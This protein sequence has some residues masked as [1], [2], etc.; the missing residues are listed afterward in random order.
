MSLCVAYVGEVI[1][2]HELRADF[3][4][5]FRRE[6]VFIEHEPLKSFVRDMM[7]DAT[8]FGQ[9]Y[10]IPE[11]RHF[12]LLSRWKGRFETRYDKEFGGFIYGKSYYK[13][14]PEFFTELL[15]E[16]TERRWERESVT[17]DK[18]DDFG[19]NYNHSHDII[20]AEVGRIVVKPEYREDFDFFF[21]AEFGK[22][23]TELFKRFVEKHFDYPGFFYAISSWRHENEKESWR[24]KYETSY[25][26][27]T[28]RFVYGLSCKYHLE[29]S[30]FFDMLD[31]ITETEVSWDT[32][33]EPM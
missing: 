13:G 24:G 1:I 8:Q 7:L 6:F 10:D 2:K 15:P 23:K 16:I 25:D 18:E 26:E 29:Y 14:P 11:W 27:E 3:G 28:G 31:E 17:Y 5:F 9:L 22:V 19:R 32:W 30:D 4:R 33:E 21:N 12:D 20:R